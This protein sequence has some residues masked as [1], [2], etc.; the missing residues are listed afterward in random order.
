V[1]LAKRNK[2][3]KWL[4]DIPA[5]T[6]VDENGGNGSRRQIKVTRHGQPEDRH[7]YPPLRVNAPVRT[8]AGNGAVLKLTK[9]T[10]FPVASGPAVHSKETLGTTIGAGEQP[11]LAAQ[12]EA[13]QGAFGGVVGEADPPVVQQARESIPT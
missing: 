6:L 9:R 5:A 8:N 3:S 12:A 2:R 7:R 1:R 13:A 11:R 4:A 10:Q